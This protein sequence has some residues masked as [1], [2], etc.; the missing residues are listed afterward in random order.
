MLLKDLVARYRDTEVVFTELLDEQLLGLAIQAANYYA[1]YSD[2]DVYGGIEMANIVDEETDI[3]NS[4][5]QIIRPLFL[6][7]CEK[8]CAVL[9]ERVAVTGIM[10]YGRSTSEIN[11]DIERMEQEILPRRAFSQPTVSLVDFDNLF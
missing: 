2:L 6:L 8:N 1:A 11:A 3:S 5:W 10:G 7:Y 4:E 9:N